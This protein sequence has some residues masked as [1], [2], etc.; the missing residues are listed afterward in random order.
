[1]KPNWT[2]YEYHPCAEV[3]QRWAIPEW[4]KQCLCNWKVLGSNPS[5]VGLQDCKRDQGHH[6]KILFLF[7]LLFFLL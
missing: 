5:G 1:M 6:G 3:C 4:V 2:K 7:L